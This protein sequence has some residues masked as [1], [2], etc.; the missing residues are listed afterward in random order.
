MSRQT[1]AFDQ[2]EDMAAAHRPQTMYVFRA[3][4]FFFPNRKTHPVVYEDAGRTPEGG[5]E[6]MAGVE[7]PCLLPSGTPSSP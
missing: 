7:T 2:A 6:E 3:Y 4:F 1:I 5:E